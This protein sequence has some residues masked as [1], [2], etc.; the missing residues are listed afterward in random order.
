M[1]VCISKG[2]LFN[3]VGDS[4]AERR[5]GINESVTNDVSSVFKD[6]TVSNW[7]TQ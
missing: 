2:T 7:S 5:G 4:G 1:Y 6:K 3:T